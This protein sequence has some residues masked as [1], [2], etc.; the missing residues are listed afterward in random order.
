MNGTFISGLRKPRCCR[1]VWTENSVVVGSYSRFY[2]KVPLKY[3]DY[4]VEQFAAD[5][6]RVVPD[7]IVRRGAY[8][9]PDVVVDAE[10]CQYWRQYRQWHHGVIP[11]QQ[12]AVVPR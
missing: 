12:S 9:A 6:V 7:A 5:G 4:T 8:V 10:L 11:G 3:A 1:F 2:D